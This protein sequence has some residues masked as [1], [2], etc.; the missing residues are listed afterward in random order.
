LLRGRDFRESE[1]DVIIANQAMAAKY[2]PGKD[3]IGQRIKGLGSSSHET[4]IIGIVANVR[5]LSLNIENTPIMYSPYRA[6]WYMH[7][8]LRSTHSPSILV[9]QVRSELAALDKGVPIYQV[10]TMVQWMDGSIAPQRS[11]LFLLGVFAALALTLAAV[12]T[13]GVLAHQVSQR[14]HEMG[15]RLALGAQPK[16]L[17]RLVIGEG[18]KL[19]LMGIAIG[20]V[21]A[22]ALTRLMASLLYQ[23]SATDPLIFAAVALLLT[24]VAVAACYLPARKAM[25]IDPLV[26]LR[27]E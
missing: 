7:L 3:P 4:E 24:L 14:T 9:G 1:S 20:T 2:W 25:R 5:E 11:N 19:A 13:Y 18:A 16:Q 22:L 21:A 27:Y 17:L 8:V 12:G 15:V 10:A 26:A 23:V 6:A